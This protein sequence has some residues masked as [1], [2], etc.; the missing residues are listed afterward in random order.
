MEHCIIIIIIIIGEREG[1]WGQPG[2]WGT[3]AI[4]VVSV[5]HQYSGIVYSMEMI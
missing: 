3:R 1:V 5:P 4:P 2:S